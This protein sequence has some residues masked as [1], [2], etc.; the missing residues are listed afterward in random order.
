MSELFKWL[1]K[2]EAKKPGIPPIHVLDSE[3]QT[4]SAPSHNPDIPSSEAA[5]AQTTL[6]SRDSFNLEL[7][8]QRI[9]IVLNAQTFPGEQFRFL[10]TRLGQLQ[11]QHGFKK[12][13]I[14]SSLPGEGK[15]FI[16]CCLAAILAQEPG[17]RVLLIDA[18]LR[19]PRTARNLGVEKGSELPGLSD[20]LKSTHRINEALLSSSSMD[21]FY[22]P[23]GRIPANPSELLASENLEQTI[24][25]TSELFDWIIID[26]PPVLNF[27]D[28]TRL[29]S[30]C[31]AVLMVVRANS[32]P[33]QIIQKSLQVVGKSL[34]CGIIMNRVQNLRVSRYYYHYYAANGRRIR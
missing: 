27:A 5:L 11:H 3:L 17:K 30:L 8:D 1:G 20:I 18:D 16:S 9:K 13:L 19:M 4:V 26:S 2:A 10:R 22:I 7:A 6:S 15:T 21:F 31:D 32:T 28:S 25:E 29:A 23:S 33:A 24:R 14:T 34:V 12:L